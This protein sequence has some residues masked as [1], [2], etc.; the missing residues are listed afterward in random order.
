M[1]PKTEEAIKIA[2]QIKND[3]ESPFSNIVKITRQYYNLAMLVGKSNEARWAGQ[4][5][6]G[7][8]SIKDVTDYRRIAHVN[9]KNNCVFILEDCEEVERRS[10]FDVLSYEYPCY[11]GLQITRDKT[12]VKRERFYNIVKQIYNRMYRETTNIL[13][14]LKFGGI[15]ETIFEENKKLIDS[16]IVDISPDAVGKFTTAY[17]RLR[18]KDP[19]SWAQ[20]VTTCRRILKDFA[21]SIYPPRSTPV[22]GRKV[23]EEE[24]VNRLWAFASEKIGSGTNRDI[25]QSEIEY[26]G[27]RIDTIYNLTNK[28]THAE[29]SK[30]EAER[31]IIRTYLLIGD[32]IKLGGL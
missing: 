5:L 4:E 7:Y 11:S 20:A 2:E 31:A 21:D 1:T 30:D 24:Y 32:L 13:I 25:V 8:K 17:E 9:E 22:N 27:Q 3:I 23:G 12:V 6:D 14:D 16:K 15:I 29:I 19:E 26:L 18:E 10:R 28:G